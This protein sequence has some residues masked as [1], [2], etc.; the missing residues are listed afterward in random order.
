MPTEA[1]SV[2]AYPDPQPGR[3][4]A[5]GPLIRIEGVNRTFTRDGKTVTALSDVSITV[6]PGEFVVLLGP[7]GCG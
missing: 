3:D 4:A 7:S 6:A 2:V 1:M 5:P